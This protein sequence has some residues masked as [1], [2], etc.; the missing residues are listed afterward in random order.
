MKTVK[1][2]VVRWGPKTSQ[3]DPDF[4]GEGVETIRR[5]RTRPS[6]GEWDGPENR[7]AGTYL[8]QSL[9]PTPTRMSPGGLLRE[10]ETGGGCVPPSGPDKD[11]RHR[12]RHEDEGGPYT[13]FGFTRPLRRPRPP[14]LHDYTKTQNG[15]CYGPR[16][17]IVE[18]FQVHPPWLGLRDDSQ[19]LWY[20]RGRQFYRPRPHS[21]DDR[22]V[23]RRPVRSGVSSRTSRHNV[24]VVRVRYGD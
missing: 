13:L 5:V 20:R 17:L 15:L 9:H 24:T 23:V 2:R 10:S 3:P 21:P 12:R 22:I 1:S 8:L 7:F 18:M 6:V 4:E 16:G 19:G 14:N 11:R